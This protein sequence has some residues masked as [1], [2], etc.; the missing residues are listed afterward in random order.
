MRNLRAQLLLSHLLLVLLMV[1]IM[2]GAVV[3]FFHLG[4]TIERIKQNNYDSVIAAV[5]MKEA[6]ERQDSAAQ[7]LLD[8]HVQEARWQYKDNAQKFVDAYE[9]EAHN[10]TEPGEQEMADDIGRQYPVYRAAIRRLLY[11]DPPMHRAQASDYYFGVLKP[12]FLRLKN[13]AQDVFDLNQNAMLHASIQARVEARRAS[14]TSVGVTVG[15]FLL[16]VGMVFWTVRAFMTPLRSLARQAEEIGVG[17]L[18]QRIELQRNDEIGALA[19]AFNHMA[20]KLREARRQEEARL[21]RAERMSDVALESLY[22]P[23]IVTDAAGRIVHLNCAAEALFGP[24]EQAINRT[25]G[26]VARDMRIAEAVEHAIHQERTSAAEGEAGFVNLQV[27]DTQRTYRL[28]ATPMREEQ[29]DLLGAVVVLEDIT[30]LRELD[31]LKTEFIGVASHELRTPVTSLLLSVQLLQEGAVGELNADQREV[32]AAQREDLERLERLMRDLLDI[33]KLES[34]VTPPHL[35][36]VAPG[37]LVEAAVRSVDAQAE[38][39]GVVLTQE[40]PANLPTIQADRSQMTRALVNLL[41]N[42]IRHTPA[43][44]KVAISARQYAGATLFMVCDTGSG[45]P[46]DYLPRIFDRFVQVPG[47][48]RGGA[49]LGLSIVRTIV[50]AHGGDIKVESELG[51]G[52]VFTITLPGSLREIS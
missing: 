8:G 28:R 48:T 2:V 23:V 46:R 44:G 6:L 50:Q 15:A 16:A 13:R 18:N 26:K 7:F 29:G 43:G 10:I 51:K 52:S 30:R 19:A 20:E 22:D 11:A 17:H 24:E 36:T 12:A 25:V 21:H 47:A 35:T 27:A 3:N 49:G 41:N 9:T 40:T 34:G 39:K 1:V 33:T 5:N 4:Q 37:E 31:Q 42:A 45:I 14:Y 38:A 32:V